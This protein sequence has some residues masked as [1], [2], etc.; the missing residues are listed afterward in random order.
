MPDPQ[1]LH[2]LLTGEFLFAAETGEADYTQ[3]LPAAQTASPHEMFV[4][5]HDVPDGFDHGG[6]G[7]DVRLAVFP[8]R[9][10]YHQPA[11]QSKGQV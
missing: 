1:G 8:H 4:T 10:P 7:R 2:W 9:L 6:K 3:E 5:C 11:G